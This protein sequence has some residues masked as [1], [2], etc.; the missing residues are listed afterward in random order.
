MKYLFYTLIFFF[1]FLSFDANAQDETK[2]ELLQE[3]VKAPKDTTRLNILYNLTQAT[4]Y[5]P[6]VRIYYIDRLLKEADEQKNG[7]KKIPTPPG[8]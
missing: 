6:Q 2:H 1:L 5:E 8:F 4:K 3:L 7:S